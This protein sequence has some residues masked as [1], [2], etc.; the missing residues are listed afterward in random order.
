MGRGDA[1]Q[2]NA[3][4]LQRLTACRFTSVALTGPATT[5]GKKA[6]AP[7]SPEMA[8]KKGSTE[9]MVAVRHTYKDLIGAEPGPEPAVERVGWVVGRGCRQ[10]QGGRHGCLSGSLGGRVARPEDTQH[11]RTNANRAPHASRAPAPAFA[12]LLEASAGAPALSSLI[13][14]PP[15]VYDAG[16]PFRNHCQPR[17]TAEDGLLQD[18]KQGLG[19]DLF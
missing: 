8:P 6:I 13:A 14:C 19:K 11:R 9:A 4:S 17:G 3:G 1:Q 2:G 16:R 7:M 10:Q 5:V 15:P 18:D 12:L